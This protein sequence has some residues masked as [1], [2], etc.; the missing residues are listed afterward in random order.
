[1]EA[2]NPATMTSAVPPANPE[3]PGQLRSDLH[4]RDRAREVVAFHRDPSRPG[5]PIRSTL[6]GAIFALVT[7]AAA[8]YVAYITWYQERISSSEGIALLGAIFVAHAVSVLV[9]TY[10]Y[11]SYDIGKALKLALVILLAAVSVLA[12]VIVVFAVLAALRDGD[13]DLGDVG[14]VIGSVGK[15]LGKLAEGALE[16]AVDSI[17]APGPAAAFAGAA[18]NTCPTCGRSLLETEG[19]MCPTCGALISGGL[20]GAI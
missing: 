4:V 17:D 6:I 12:V 7:F 9:F 3:V 16:S 14:D 20:G 2:Y 19:P 18:V 11:E 15:G 1:M 13:A 10:A 8:I 5:R